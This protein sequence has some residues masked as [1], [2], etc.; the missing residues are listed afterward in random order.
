MS[1]PDLAEAGTLAEFVPKRKPP[2]TYKTL[3]HNGFQIYHGLDAALLLAYDMADS[4]DS[5]SLSPPR[6]R[7]LL[8]A[9]PL[10]RPERAP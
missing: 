4:A 1:C 6:R 8:G 3:I 10:L 5:L 7:V 9:D 2:L